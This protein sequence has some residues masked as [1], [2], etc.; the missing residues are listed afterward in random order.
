VT[1]GD[2]AMTI[3]R[4]TLLKLG[5]TGATLTAGG[6][7]VPFGSS[8]STKSV[9]TLRDANFPTPWAAEFIAGPVLRGQRYWG[10]LPDGT[11]GEY[12]LITVI[13]KEGNANIV[14]GRRT[15]VYGYAYLDDDGAE[16]L[17]R[18]PG[19]TIEVDRGTPV[20]LRVRNQLPLIHPQFGHLRDLDPPARLGVPASV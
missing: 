12:R 13:E 5:A 7:L 1:E 18:V 14:P 8:A 17:V 2:T 20:K 10:K 15:P 9:S 16:R 11:E 6:L 3:S 4:R 19:P